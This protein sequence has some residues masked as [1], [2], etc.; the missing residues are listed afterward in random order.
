VTPIDTKVYTQQ[1][2]VIGKVSDGGA[3]ISDFTITNNGVDVTPENTLCSDGS[4]SVPIYLNR[5]NNE[6][7]INATNSNDQDADPLTMNV[8]WYKKWTVINFLD[9][10]SGNDADSIETNIENNYQKIKAFGSSNDIDNII[11]FK[12]QDTSTFASIVTSSNNDTFIPLKNIDANWI[13]SNNIDIASIETFSKYVTYSIINFPSD[14]YCVNFKCHGAG[15]FFLYDDQYKDVLK[16][17]DLSC[18]KV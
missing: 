16:E 12:D 14:H 6:I 11:L 13:D 4:F 8:A 15:W 2:T 7:I 18:T 17:I 3:S 10:S 9:A 1:V 5:G